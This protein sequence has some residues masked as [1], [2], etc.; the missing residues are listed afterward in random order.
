MDTSPAASTH[1]QQPHPRTLSRTGS[2]SVSA[3]GSAY[4][5]NGSARSDIDAARSR[6]RSVA[7]SSE[8]AEGD[9]DDEDMQNRGPWPVTADN[10]GRIPEAE[11]LAP[12][13]RLPNTVAQG[14]ADDEYDDEDGFHQPGVPADGMVPRRKIGPTHVG[15][16]GEHGQPVPGVPPELDPR[17]A[18]FR[19]P[20]SPGAASV[21]SLAVQPPASPKAA[22]ADGDTTESGGAY[23]STPSMSGTE[24]PTVPSRTSFSLPSPSVNSS[25]ASIFSGPPSASMTGGLG[26]PLSAGPGSTFS[27]LMTGTPGTGMAPPGVAASVAATAG[28][29]SS[30]SSVGHSRP[31]SIR[32]PSPPLSVVS[33]PGSDV[34]MGPA[35]AATAS[36]VVPPP[37]LMAGAGAYTGSFR[38]SGY[39]AGPSMLS[40]QAALASHAPSEV[41]S[42]ETTS[43]LDRPLSIGGGGAGSHNDDTMETEGEA[44]RMDEEEDGEPDGGDAISRRANNIERQRMREREQ[45]GGEAGVGGLSRPPA[46]ASLAA[47]MRQDRTLTGFGPGGSLP[48]RPGSTA[49]TIGTASPPQSASSS[50]DEGHGLSSV[51]AAVR[52]GSGA[53]GR[54]DSV[55]ASPVYGHPQ[56]QTPPLRPSPAFAFD[57]AGPPPSATRGNAAA[58]A[59]GQAAPLVQGDML[60]AS[61]FAHRSRRSSIESTETIASSSH[62]PAT[63]SS[64]ASDG[65]RAE[66]W[67]AT[68]GGAGGVGAM[69]GPGALTGQEALFE[70]A[71]V[72]G[73]ELRTRRLEETILLDGPQIGFGKPGTPTGEERMQF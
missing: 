36:S 1:Q 41:G 54:E 70:E 23:T 24:L 38:T 2:G 43:S 3:A 4:M 13:I 22:P 9:I 31:S 19:R 27:P 56:M 17:A 45:L 5:A 30:A 50:S 11:Q 29:S 32:A 47:L 57:P 60:G 26:T 58:A 40:R 72:I 37:A 21:F 28:S 73:P 34:S 7:G 20:T 63:V 53:L 61:E 71:A 66:L 62:Q 69:Q 8:S 49:A 16:F 12:G 33:A 65:D 6:G 52:R 51:A 10:L 55:P 18:K 25:S 46:T 35:S 67:V 68:G 39:Q 44:R 64:G 59:A 42:V 48:S 14:G 15:H